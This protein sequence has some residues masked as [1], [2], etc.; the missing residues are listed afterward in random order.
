MESNTNNGNKMKTELTNAM[1]EGVKSA[2]AH[3][4][5]LFEAGDYTRE[6]MLAANASIRAAL[7]AWNLSL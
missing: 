4:A 3:R 2:E 1:I 6:E 5:R 7:D